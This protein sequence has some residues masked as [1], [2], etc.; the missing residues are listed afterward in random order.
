MV[1]Y[2]YK[3][4]GFGGSLTKGGLVG[5]GAFIFCAALVLL[6]QSSTDLIIQEASTLGLACVLAIVCQIGYVLISTLSKL[7]RGRQR[8][9]SYHGII[10]E[11]LGIIIVSLVAVVLII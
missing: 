8:D 7:F 5:G 1:D 2:V 10:A 11:A 9:S 6:I 4:D 3:E